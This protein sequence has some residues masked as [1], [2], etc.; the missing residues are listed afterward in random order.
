MKKHLESEGKLINWE[1]VTKGEVVGRHVRQH[2]LTTLSELLLKFT[3]T[4]PFEHRQ[5]LPWFTEQLGQLIKNG[6]LL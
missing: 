1:G 4:K 3:K 5:S 2:F 6:I